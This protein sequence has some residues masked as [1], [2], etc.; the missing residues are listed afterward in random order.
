MEMRAGAIV[1][2]LITEFVLSLA[3]GAAVAYWIWQSASASGDASTSHLLDVAAQVQNMATAQL[4]IF[5]GSMGAALLGGYVAG[6]MGRPASLSNALCMGAIAAAL[7]VWVAVTQVQTV[8]QAQGVARALAIIPAALVG[9]WLASVNS[10]TRPA[11]Q[12]FR[13]DPRS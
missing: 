9:G 10:R 11:Q 5:A 13:A 4:L 8:M 2:G 3:V 6:H 1:T 12:A 7:P